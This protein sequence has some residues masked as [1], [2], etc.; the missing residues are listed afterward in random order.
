MVELGVGVGEDSFV[1]DSLVPL[2]CGLVVCFFCGCAMEFPSALKKSANERASAGVLLRQI[3]SEIS[4][5]I[6]AS[7]R[8]IQR[9]Q[10]ASLKNVPILFGLG[11]S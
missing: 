9:G 11:Q 4:T 5:I 7:R 6:F 10:S 3:P 1:P 8:C 2:L